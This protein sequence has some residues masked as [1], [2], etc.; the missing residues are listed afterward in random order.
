MSRGSHSHHHSSRS[1]H[2]SS[3]S[4]NNKEE[5]EEDFIMSEPGGNPNVD[6]CV[7]LCS[8]GF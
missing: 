7:V 6:Y 4:N 1:G 2:A 3:L 5:E 8:K